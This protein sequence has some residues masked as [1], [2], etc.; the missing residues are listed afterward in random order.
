MQRPTVLPECQQTFRNDKEFVCV[1]FSFDHLY[2]CSID[3]ADSNFYYNL[4]YPKT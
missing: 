3:I 1:F 4:C 2:I